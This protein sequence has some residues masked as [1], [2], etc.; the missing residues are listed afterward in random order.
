MKWQTEVFGS[1]KYIKVNALEEKFYH[2]ID[3][4]R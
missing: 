3:E 4:K 2:R 1:I